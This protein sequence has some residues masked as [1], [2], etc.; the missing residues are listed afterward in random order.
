ETGEC[1]KFGCTYEFL[2]TNQTKYCFTAQGRSDFFPMTMDKSKEICITINETKGNSIYLYAVAISVSIVVILLLIL[3]LY[4][5]IRIIKAKPVLPLS[6][7]NFAKVVQTQ[8]NLPSGQMT[9]Y[10]QVSI[11]PVDSPEE[12]TTPEEAEKNL[13]VSDEPD[14]GDSIDNGYHSS[15]GET[16]QKADEDQSGNEEP[17]S[18]RNYYRTESNDSSVVCMTED[19]VKPVTNSF[20]YDKPHCPL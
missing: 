14:L 3:S 20:G 12:K 16:E 4:V 15:V 8:I 19:H 11:S 17:S 13:I 7:N 6:L 9:K 1:D 2:I 10:D 5:I 18:S